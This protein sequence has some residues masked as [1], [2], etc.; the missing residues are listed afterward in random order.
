VNDLFEYALRN[1]GDSDMVGITIR[2][3]VDQNDKPIGISFRR[4]DQLSEDVIWSVFEKVSQ[5]NSRYNAL[6]RLVVTVHSVKMPVGF[7]RRALNTMGRPIFVVAH[8]K[9]SIIEVK[10]EDNCLAHA[11][12]IAI[13]RVNNDSNYNSYHRGD[14]IRP[15]VENLLATTGI[16]L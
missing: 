11:L 14:K 12:M 4:K 1:A 5:S 15:A 3:E 16:D 2:N 8:F 10:A 6:N 9:R 7:G 13:A